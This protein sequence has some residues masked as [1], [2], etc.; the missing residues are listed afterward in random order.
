M[1]GEK[2][3]ERQHLERN[4]HEVDTKANTVHSVLSI[5][6]QHSSNATLGGVKNQKLNAFR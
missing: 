4:G 5:T 2:G 3:D 6:K 1:E